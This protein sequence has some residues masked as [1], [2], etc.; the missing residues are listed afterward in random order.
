[1]TGPGFG[2]GLVA[3]VVTQALK[4]P[5]R[6]ASVGAPPTHAV[7]AGGAVTSIWNSTTVC[8]V[9]KAGKTYTVIAYVP[10]P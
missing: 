4:N 7:R 9:S 3:S 1:L 5:S 8:D 2:R 10:V 6:R